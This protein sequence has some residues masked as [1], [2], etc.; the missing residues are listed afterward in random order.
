MTRSRASGRRPTPTPP[1]GASVALA[2]LS[3][4]LAGL[5]AL[6]LAH[7]PDARVADRVARL[8]APDGTVA[9]AEDAALNALRIPDRALAATLRVDLF[10]P[11][12]PPP[13]P[14]PAQREQAAARL[15]VELVAILITASAQG[16]PPVRRAFLYD[17]K[18][19]TYATL[20]VGDALREGVTLAALDDVSATFA[21]ARGPADVARTL[22]MELNP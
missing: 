16:E 2:A 3:T 13:E 1:V 22:R 5:L 14:P 8:D 18:A 12:P 4:A 15:D 9:E 6:R 19:Q 10:P 21:V 11:P 20:A 17:P 7:A